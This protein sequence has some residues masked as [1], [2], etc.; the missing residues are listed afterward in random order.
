MSPLAVRIGAGVLAL[1]ALI[2]LRGKRW[3]YLTFVLLGL[4]YFP[5]QTHFRVHA[6]KCE[7][8]LPTLHLLVPLLHN[9]AYIALF[10]GFYWMS[11]AQFRTSDAR[12]I[13]ALLATLLVG[14]DI[15]ACRIS[16]R[17]PQE[18]WA[19]RCCSQ[20]G[21]G[22][23]GNLRTSD[24]SGLVQRPLLT[25]LPRRLGLSFLLA[26][27]FRPRRRGESFDRRLTF[28]RARALLRRRRTSLGRK[29]LRTA[30]MSLHADRSF[31]TSRR[32]WDV[33]EEC[34]N[35]C[36]RSYLDVAA[37]SSLAASSWRLWGPGRS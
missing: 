9:Y 17:T 13:W 24:S 21:P 7:Q 16:Y 33:S 22:S 28:H 12:A 26:V 27:S 30:R 11:W 3:A 10:A 15:A 14:G 1:L 34:H 25:R 5:A 2:A 36:G 6:P 20:A 29:R 18:S 31:N 37:R 8:L 19:Q 4:L 23:A 32:S 35:A